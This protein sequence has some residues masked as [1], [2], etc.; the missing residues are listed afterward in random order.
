MNR[1]AVKAA[2]FVGEGHNMTVTGRNVLVTEAMKQ[3]A[4]EKLL[5]IE[6]FNLRIIDIVVTMDVQKLEQRVDIT[7]KLDHVL[8]RSHAATEDMYA[9]IDQAV[10]KIQT[11]IRRYRGRIR[12]HQAKGVSFIDMNVNVLRSPREEELLELNGEI[13]EEN[14]R[15]L[16][17]KYRP[18]E[19][20]DTETLP[21][22]ILTYDEAVMKMDLSGQAFLIFRNEVDQKLKVIYRRN[23]SNYGVIEPEA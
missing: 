16:M 13:D 1:K 14:Q 15:S 2:E 7:L 21:L 10:D 5:K 9:S 17:S 19:I 18:H 12:D 11:Q 20:V 22:K 8:I 6:R 4:L 23:D 3:Y